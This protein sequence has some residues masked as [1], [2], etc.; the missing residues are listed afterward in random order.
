[1][2][3]S[4]IIVNYNVKAFLEQA[5]TS[6]RKA[7]DGLPSE[8]I[9]VDNGSGDGSVPMMRK[10]FPDVHII[11][12]HENVGF[13]RANNQALTKAKG[14]YCCLVN[15]DTLVRED[16]FRVCVD[17]LEVQPDVGAVGCKI[18]NPDGTLQLSCRRSIPTP[19]VAF[20][21]VSGLSALFSGSKTF[22]RYNL[23]YLDPDKVSEV[24]AL[25]GSFM[26]VRS[27]AVDAA[28]MLDED[29][30]MYGED[31]DW[32]YRIGKAGWK[33]VYLPDTQIIHYKGQSTKE[34][35]FDALHMFY[36]AMRL[37]VKK[38]FHGGWS[39]LPLWFLL[40]GIRIRGGLSFLHRLSRRLLVP[41]VDAA[42]LQTG[43]V[44]ALLI[45]FGHLRY[46]PSY[47]LVDGIYTLVWM[48]TLFALGLYDR[49]PASV[50]KAIA[51]ILIGLIF[52]TSLTFFFPE[53]AFSRQVVLMAGLLDAIFLG[54][55][56]IVYRGI[57]GGGMAKRGK[58][59][60]IVGTDEIGRRVMERLKKRIDKR[61]EVVGFLSADEA[62][63]FTETDSET[64]VLGLMDDLERIVK[65]HQ[66]E[67]IIFSSDA[68]SYGDV[69]NIVS[70]I[71][72]LRVEFKMV[73]QEADVLI[74]RTSIDTLEDLPLIDLDYRIFRGPNVFFKR[75]MD[76][77]GGLFLLPFVVPVLLMVWILPGYRF[78]R[79]TINDG[80]GGTCRVW[81]V[82]KDGHRVS[83]WG[84]IVFAVEL[85]RGRISLVGSEIDIDATQVSGFKPGITGL[86]Q[87]QK[88]EI[89]DSGERKRLQLYYMKNYSPFLDI[90]IL[91]KS[92]FRI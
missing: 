67:E 9:V 30:F 87:V 69:L 44:L 60:I 65:T 18:L 85:L 34:A 24:E 40:L 4:V 14:K 13:A 29:F 78:G 17:Y 70:R 20:T 46:I 92:L 47:H 77:I 58:R 35:T 31:L 3:L 28:G 88:G 75:M 19:W 56:R 32:C 21:K 53:Y 59:V 79:N 51:G 26:F 66:V 15:P 43:L 50:S 52:N 71:K 2:I 12:N 74:G 45:R 63:L 90:D 6:I 42:F 36:E 23:T 33:I 41:V 83:G 1:M 89:I 10:R 72:D 27:K 62:G 73:P 80:R 7:L 91:L 22:G 55:W 48:G 8:I 49:R 68:G 38:H 64:P 61:Y 57:A 16:T 81:S 25:S 37:F 82:T 86:V 39:V 76:L 5:L 84:Y 54:G 11:E